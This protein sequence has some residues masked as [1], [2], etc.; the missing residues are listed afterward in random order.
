MTLLKFVLL[1]FMLCISW[2]T[3]LAAPSATWV[4]S[5]RIMIS[6]SFMGHFLFTMALAFHLIRTRQVCMVLHD[7]IMMIVNIKFVL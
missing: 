1:K 2:V 3:V 5:F 4:P 7:C 6:G